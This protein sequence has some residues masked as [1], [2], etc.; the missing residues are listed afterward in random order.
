MSKDLM[1]FRLN[2]K[3][4]DWLRKESKEKGISQAKIVEESIKL[5]QL[6]RLI[7]K[8]DSNTTQEGAIQ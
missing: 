8:K 3:V 7:D 4:C 2:T 5:Y 1:A 6:M